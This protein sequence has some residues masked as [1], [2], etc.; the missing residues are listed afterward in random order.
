MLNSKITILD[1]IG[2]LK[3]RYPVVE[4]TM[5]TAEKIDELEN[6]FA[7]YRRDLSS[8]LFDAYSVFHVD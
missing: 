4:E 2:Y 7:S 3:S 8:F 6:L 1:F 5:E